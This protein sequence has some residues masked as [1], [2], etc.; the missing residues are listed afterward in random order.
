M[1]NL[2]IR[3]KEVGLFPQAP[4]VHTSI[5]NSMTNEIGPDI[6]VL[7]TLIIDGVLGY[8]ERALIIAVN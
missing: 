7:R 8:G 3:R 5:R 1:S 2:P 6:N 4:R